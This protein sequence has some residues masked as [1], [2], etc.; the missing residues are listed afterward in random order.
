MGETV[1][2]KEATRNHA[3]SA[4]IFGAHRKAYIGDKWAFH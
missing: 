4:S 2:Y 1:F 3:E